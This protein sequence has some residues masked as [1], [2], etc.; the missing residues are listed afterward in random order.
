MTSVTGGGV[1]VVVSVA[2][3]TGTSILMWMGAGETVSLKITA[4]G[5]K[6]SCK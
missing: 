5:V 1:M 4:C 6:V 3:G 2:G